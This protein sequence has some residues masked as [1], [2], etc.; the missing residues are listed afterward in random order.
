MSTPW[1]K[2]L[3]KELGQIK[4]EQPKLRLKGEETQLKEEEASKDKIPTD[5]QPSETLRILKE[6]VA[7]SEQVKQI[8]NR[9]HAARDLDQI[10][11]DLMDELLKMFDSE[12]LTGPTP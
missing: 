3:E 6:Q 7:F 5:P 8:M 1:I 10:F 9:I 12:R 11:V 2:V 4:G